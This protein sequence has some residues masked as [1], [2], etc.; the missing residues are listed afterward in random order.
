MNN[1]INYKHTSLCCLLWISVIVLLSGC[2]QNE[3]ITSKSESDILIPIEI[4]GIHVAQSKSIETQPYTADRVLILPFKKINES[5]ITNDDTNFA[6]DYANA[7]QVNINSTTSYMTMLNLTASST[8]KVLVIG[9][10]RN[11]YDFN[12]QGSVS[13][14]F[15][16]GSV[17]L[18]TTLSNFHLLSGSAASIP[19]FFTATCQSYNGATLIGAYFKPNQIKTLK[20]NLTRL[21]SGLNVD[22]TNIP[23]YITSITLIAE[24]LVKGIKPTDG[25]ATVLQLATDADN[26][27]T[28]STKIPASGKVSFNHY[29]LPTLDLNKTKLY[30]DVKYGAFTERYMIKVPDSAGVSATN[31]ITFTS[32]HVV[33]I[34]GNYTL[35]NLG[36]TIN[37]NINL[38][39]NSWDGIQ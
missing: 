39:D 30:L 36:F 16:I 28:F 19:E 2:S 13:N 37:G 24:K 4:T 20:A 33:S 25:T 12:N 27:K 34:T 17:T 7:K 11:D 29:I 26:L 3:D 23:T 10:N 35:I 14:R 38:D 21:V 6:P 8:Y 15:S 9:Y 31:S 5:I 32:N 1:N 18:P 22:I